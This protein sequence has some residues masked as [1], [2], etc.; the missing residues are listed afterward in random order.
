MMKPEDKQ[1]IIEEEEKLPKIQIVKRAVEKKPWCASGAALCVAI[2]AVVISLGVL[3][4]CMGYF[5]VLPEKVRFLN[6]ESIQ[7][8]L[9]FFFQSLPNSVFL[10]KS[11]SMSNASVNWSM[12][13][14]AFCLR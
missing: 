3:V 13:T 7:K 12:K 2:L 14:S 8:I 9:N 11:I 4:A 10:I 5:G 1:K 6:F